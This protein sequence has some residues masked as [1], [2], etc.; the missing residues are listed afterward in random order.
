[1]SQVFRLRHLVL[2]RP[3]NVLL[4]NFSQI[5][6]FVIKSKI[7][8]E[9]FR[10]R[11]LVLKRP[12]CTLQNFSQIISFVIKVINLDLYTLEFRK[13]LQLGKS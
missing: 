13:Y 8:L 10:L 6:S 1:M 11:H 9:V 3:H 2:K 7:N 12:Q 4:Q 5:I